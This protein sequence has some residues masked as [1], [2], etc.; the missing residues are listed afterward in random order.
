MY[1]IFSFFYTSKSEYKLDT[2]YPVT[3]CYRQDLN[4][5]TITPIYKYLETNKDLTMVKYISIC[6][7]SYTSFNYIATVMILMLDRFYPNYETETKPIFSD[8][9]NLEPKST[10]SLYCAVRESRFGSVFLDPM[11]IY[12]VVCHIKTTS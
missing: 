8:L 1:S 11:C 2:K 3:K 9:Q 12:C 7:H 6:L 5:V 10:Q 4:S